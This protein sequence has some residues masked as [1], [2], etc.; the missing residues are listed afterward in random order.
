MSQEL[1][2]SKQ[3]PEAAR[4]PAARD[5]VIVAL[6]VPDTAAALG[7]AR[8][9]GGRVSTFKVGMQLYYEEGPPI[10][11]ALRETGSRVFC[12]LKLHD[13]PNTVGR[14]AAVLAGQGVHM[15]TV[16]AA[17]GRAMLEA[18][19]RGA[20]ERARSAGRPAPLVLAVTVLTSL[21]QRSLEDEVGIR[22]DLA[23]QAVFWARL[24]RQAGLDGVVASA[25]E[26]ARIKA[27]CG[28]DFLVVAPG[29]RPAAGEAH[30][31]DDQRR[32]LTPAEAT[33]AGADRLVVGRPVLEAPDPE[34]ALDRILAEVEGVLG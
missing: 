17:G 27:A 7:W 4:R 8:R 28:A 33:S 29:I 26:A 9:L 31:A 19:V 23:E 34:A 14:A 11:A 6:D 24:A 3:A 13:I 1:A 32:V 21:D 22:E 12:D 16:H 5:R 25:R 30:R 2:G 15:F 18:A 20:R 10:V